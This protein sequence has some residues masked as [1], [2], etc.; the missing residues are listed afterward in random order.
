MCLKPRPMPPIPEDTRRIALQIFPSKHLPIRFGDEY[1]DVLKD[2]DFADLYSN[3]GQPALPP[4]FLIL[5]MILQ[6]LERASDRM[7]VAMVCARI[8]WKYALH[9]P[10]SDPGFDASVLCEFRARLAKNQAQRRAFDAFLERL[11]E[12]GFLQGRRVQRTDSIAVLGAVRDLN[13]LELVMETLRLALEAIQRADP[14]WFSQHVPE[15]WLDRY[16]EWT[17]AERLVK[18]DGTKGVAES[19]ALLL[20]TGRDGFVLLNA[21]QCSSNAAHSGN[22]AQNTLMELEAVELFKVV[23]QQQY[24]QV[25]QE[26][27]PTDLPVEEQF[28][29]QAAAVRRVDRRAKQKASTDE[30][31]ATQP[32]A[33]EPA[34][35]EPATEPAATE[36]AA[37]EPVVELSSAENRETRSDPSSIVVTPHDPE[38]RFRIK[39]GKKHT[40]YKLHLTETATADAPKL[41]TDIDVVAAASHD[42]AA[43]D[44]IQE[45]LSQRDLLPETH[46]ADAGYVSGA[47]LQS[48][49]ERGLILLGPVSPDT[50]TPER[51]AAGCALDDFIVDFTAQQALCPAGRLSVG[52]QTKPRADQPRLQR[53]IIRWDPQSC[54]GCEL[55]SVCV[56]P[57]LPYRVLTV[58]EHHEKILA[59]RKEQ[60]TEAFK[61]QYRNRAGIEA[62]FSHMVN[63]H[64]SRATPYKGRDK[65]LLYYTQLCI[66]M[67]I[68]RVIAWEEGV[69]PKTQRRNNLRRLSLIHSSAADTTQTSQQAT[70][71]EELTNAA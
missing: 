31:A 28:C 36:P 12:K 47:T 56:G 24:R 26:V 35:T 68:K 44:P 52:W 54:G 4:S 21:L 69:K 16:G 30:P 53:V 59:R 63:V 58:S 17:Q 50:S 55:R 20:R 18:E 1:A 11:K 46:L 19:R 37:T 41:I 38:A 34:A 61:E 5:V 13:R 33:T 60:K 9:L 45:R 51:K 43:I 57:K 7:A 3:T 22:A 49:H 67:N 42:G 64:R 40:G 8:D 25:E 39:R 66:G 32:A 10:L 23:W 70:S 65:T 2:E 15:E 6:Y 62:T 71:P 29:E 14:A 48:S 27:K